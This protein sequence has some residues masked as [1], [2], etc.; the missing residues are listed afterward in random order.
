VDGDVVVV[1]AQADQVVGIM[2][3]VVSSFLDVVGLGPTLGPE[4]TVA[5]ASPNDWA[6]RVASTNTS[7]PPER[8]DG[9]GGSPPLGSETEGG[10]EAVG[11][12]SDG[13]GIPLRLGSPARRA[14]SPGLLARWRKAASPAV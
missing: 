6:A 14:T 5:P 1:P 13:F 8:S 10:G 11:D 2:A 7:P 9:G 12:V 4:E 3:A